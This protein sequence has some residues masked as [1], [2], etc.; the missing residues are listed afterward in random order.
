VPIESRVHRGYWRTALGAGIAGAATCAL[1]LVDYESFRVEGPHGAETVSLL[2]ALALWVAVG[3]AAGLVSGR[4]R[5]A[6]VSWVAALVGVLLAHQIF[7]V[8]L[9][10]DARY[11]GEDGFE[12]D[13]VPIAVFLL[14]IIGGG[15]L[16][17]AAASRR[18]GRQKLNGIQREVTPTFADRPGA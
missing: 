2:A 13:F 16:L 10:P 14:L 9:F 5:D 15:H 6:P 1:I 4:F 3:A 18:L 7:Y 8:A 12:G 11:W 17:G